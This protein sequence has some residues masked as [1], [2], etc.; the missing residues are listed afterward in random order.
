MSLPGLRR[1]RRPESLQGGN[2]SKSFA[3]T[4][5]MR[6]SNFRRLPPPK[7]LPRGPRTLPKP[8]QP[9]QALQGPTFRSSCCFDCK[10]S[11]KPRPNLAPTVFRIGSIQSGRRPKKASW[12]KGLEGSIKLNKHME[13]RARP[14]A[15]L[16]PTCHRQVHLFRIGGIQSGR[17]LKKT[18]SSQTQTQTCPGSRLEGLQAGSISISARTLEPNQPK[19]CIQVPRQGP[20]S[21]WTGAKNM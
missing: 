14:S 11:P 1:T 16:A 9:S 15:N 4:P 19:P 20:I 21:K 18:A 7:N 12:L 6:P 3:T 10:A 2:G 5:K 13:P 17:H 8:S